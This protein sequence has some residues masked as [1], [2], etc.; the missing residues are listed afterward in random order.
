MNLR[1]RMSQ[2]KK[3][4]CITVKYDEIQELKKQQSYTEKKFYDTGFKDGKKENKKEIA[5]SLG[6]FDIFETL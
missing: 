6:L 2:V 1:I 3:G 4:E 5:E